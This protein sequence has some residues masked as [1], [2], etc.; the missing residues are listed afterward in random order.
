MVRGLRPRNK[1]GGWLGGRDP[2]GGEM[3]PS[4]TSLRSRMGR[5]LCNGFSRTSWG[6]RLRQKAVPV[7]CFCFPAEVQ[8]WPEDSSGQRFLTR[9]TLR[10]PRSSDD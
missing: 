1:G 4:S 9:D 6:A 10:N 5:F 7:G 8:G 2:G 3:A